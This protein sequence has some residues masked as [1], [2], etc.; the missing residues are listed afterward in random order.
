MIGES[1][2]KV[3]LQRAQWVRLVVVGIFVAFA[4]ARVVPDVIRAWEPLGTFGYVTDGDGIVVHVTAQPQPRLERAKP[5]HA[6]PQVRKRKGAKAAAEPKPIAP[7][8]RRVELGDR[9]LVSA[10]PAFDRKPG[11]VG[12]AGSYTYDN[13]ERVLP[14]VRAGKRHD[15]HLTA[16]DEPMQSR[17]LTVLRIV[18]LAIVLGFAAILFLIQPSI[19]TAALLAYALGGG[20]PATFSNLVIDNPWRQIP[21]IVGELLAGTSRAALLLFAACLVTD[22]PQMQRRFAVV[23]GTI[24]L[25]LGAALA[26]GDWWL[27]YGAHPARA[28]DDAATSVSIAL[29]GITIGTFVYAFAR[30]SGLGRQRIGLLVGSF[31]LA[32]A[33]QL[34]SDTFYPARIAPWENGLLL[35]ARV[36]PI[37]GVWIAVL[38]HQFFNIDWVV[39]RAVVYVALTAAF[40]GTLA[41]AEE[42]GTYLFYNNTDLAYGF[43]I[44]ITMA[45][46]TLTGRIKDLLD[47]V[48]DRFIF[49]DRRTQRLA[50]EFIAGYILDAQSVDDVYRALLEDAAHA[51]KLSFGGILTR[52]ATGDYALSYNYNWPD[53]CVVNLAASDT[54]TRS[55]SRTRG[56]MTFSGKDTRLIQK[57]FPTERLTFAAPLFFDRHVSA[58]VVYGHSVSGLD[59]DP[60]E[61]ELLVRVIAHASIALNAIELERYRAAAAD[62]PEAAVRG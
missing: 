56:A 62:R 9:V 4:L 37:V 12:P 35:S 18:I 21:E 50:L 58:I 42:L 36:L 28:V 7:E 32:G 11:L 5:P 44:A 55:I 1:L 24:G 59:L 3:K 53:D 23:A 60:D 57:A 38:R 29:G 40:F 22:R 54:L 61:R 26:F 8:D 51:L 45:V 25:A 16:R 31:A 19:A 17:V 30:S 10:I 43:L 48:V 41:V 52:K 46:G 47:H 2:P 14:V 13:R 34:A 39:S 33:A 49:R 6:K 15:L 20:F 27:T